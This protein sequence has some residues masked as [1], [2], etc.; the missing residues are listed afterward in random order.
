[1]NKV[2]EVKHLLN[3][4]K[5]FY[6]PEN[7]ESKK[8][9]GHEIEH[10]KGVLHRSKQITDIVKDKTKEPL[11][12][13]LVSTIAALHDIGNVISR[14]YHG[15]VGLG[16][17][18]G[19]LTIDDICNSPIKI[20]DER[21][22]TN[23]EINNIKKCIV[24]DYKD[25]DELTAIEQK[26]MEKILAAQVVFQLGYNGVP[27]DKCLD[28]IKYNCNID[29]KIAQRIYINEITHYDKENYSR[30]YKD[31]NVN[32]SKELQNITKEIQD[33]YLKNSK[34]L[35]VIAE[36]VQDHNV[37]WCGDETG[38]KTR[39][40]AR[41]IYGMIIADADKDNIPET[42]ALR[43][44][45]FAI[46]KW[47]ESNK[48]DFFYHDR[49]SHHLINIDSCLTHICHQAN[50]RFRMAFNP[51]LGEKQMPLSDTIFRYKKLEDIKGVTEIKSEEQ[52]EQYKKE[53]HEIFTVPDV[54]K[55][56]DKNPDVGK[57]YIITFKAGDDV[58]SQIDNMFGGNDVLALRKD[59]FNTMKE[60]AEPD[61]EQEMIAKFNQELMPLWNNAATIEEAV[62]I[63]EA[64]FWNSSL[65]DIS[66]ENHVNEV[67]EYSQMNELMDD[68]IDSAMSE[69]AD[70][71][72]ITN[73]ELIESNKW[74]NVIDDVIPDDDFTL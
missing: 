44:L 17:I 70:T 50:E 7:P 47:A 61:R 41:S 1:M 54:N 46:N 66:F 21:F 42:F 31:V 24:S 32:H 71:E 49:H 5:K 72:E 40:E 10:I 63:V 34:E 57:Q 15:N 12:Y 74:E 36:A 22:L 14:K 4:L 8:G 9:I 55:G 67:L 30:A 6:E 33:V 58:Y 48:D 53:G 27:F 39:F 37:D 69:L 68:I 38:A 62:D 28:Y 59:F 64:K 52:L 35:S 11:D 20:N 65:N 45:A 26:G 13:K 56:Y 73:K 3:N 43:T 29:D 18:K 51:S 16:I 25:Y 2:S 60:Y 23:P 19:E